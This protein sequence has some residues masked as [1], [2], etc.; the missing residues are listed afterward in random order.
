MQVKNRVAD[1]GMTE[2]HLNGAQ[3]H[4][5]FEQMGRKTVPE[6]VRMNFGRKPGPFRRMAAGKPNNL[7]RDRLIGS[8][9]LA[10]KQIRLGFLPAPV[11]AQGV[12]Q[13]WAERHITVLTALALPDMD[14]HALAVD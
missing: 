10:G 5:G 3:V 14:H 2:Q 13:S 8:P 1:V 11:L 6:R 4:A 9:T 7:V 12:E